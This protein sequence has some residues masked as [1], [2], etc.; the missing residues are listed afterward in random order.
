MSE[1]APKPSVH[2]GTGEESIVNELWKMAKDQGVNAQMMAFQAEMTR[3][4]NVAMRAFNAS[5]DKWSRRLF[6]LTFV[7]AGLTTILMALTWA[8]LERTP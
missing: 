4:N 2:E 8:L 3:R 1:G 7:L 5:S 6:W